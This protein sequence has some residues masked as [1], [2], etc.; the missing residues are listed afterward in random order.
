MKNWGGLKLLKQITNMA[1][2]TKNW[3]KIRKTKSKSWLLAEYSNKSP[4][5]KKSKTILIY[6]D[7][8]YSN[9]KVWVGKTDGSNDGEYHWF[10]KKED[11]VKFANS[12]MEKNK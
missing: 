5:F 2:K 9:Y 8:P 10:D 3:G 11:A 4:S 6:P 1:Y 7:K 12:Y